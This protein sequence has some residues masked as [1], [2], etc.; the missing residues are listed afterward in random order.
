MIW[1]DAT[2]AYHILFLFVANIVYL[3]ARRERRRRRRGFTT[4]SLPLACL[5]LLRRLRVLRFERRA[6]R[7]D[8]SPNR[9]F[10]ENMRNE[11]IY[12]QEKEPSFP[13]YILCF[14]KDREMT[15][16]PKMTKLTKLTNSC[17]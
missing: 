2:S 4:S 13:V 9:F 17:W 6:L 14:Q 16:M 5:T 11:W 3:R 15:Q 1:I 10:N 12:T 7:L 8:L